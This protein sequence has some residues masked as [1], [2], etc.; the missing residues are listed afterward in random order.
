MLLI[1][2]PDQILQLKTPPQPHSRIRYQLLSAAYK[3]Q[4]A[5]Q[6]L[7]QAL[8][9]RLCT[10]ALPTTGSQNA[11]H[12]PV[13]SF[14]TCSFLCLRCSC[15]YCLLKCWIC[16]D[17]PQVNR[18]TPTTVAL[19]PQ[20]ALVMTRCPYCGLGPVKQFVINDPVMHPRTSST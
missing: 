1:G 15:L 7:L 9:F 5:L 4:L 2:V 14:C 19:H 18:P 12:S 10:L 3:H 11:P 16:C 8:F 20:C 6:P 13:P 17:N